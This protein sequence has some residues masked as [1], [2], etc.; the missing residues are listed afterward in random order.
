MLFFSSLTAYG[1]M[2]LF[3][4]TIWSTWG[5][6]MIVNNRVEAKELFRSEVKAKAHHL[7]DPDYLET[8]AL[9]QN[10]FKALAEGS[11]KLSIGEYEI[12]IKD[13]ES[14]EVKSLCKLA[15]AFFHARQ[16]LTVDKDFI[17]NI[18]RVQKKQALGNWSRLNKLK[19][20]V[21]VYENP[22]TKGSA[23]PDLQEQLLG[24]IKVSAP[25]IKKMEKTERWKKIAI[26]SG[27]LLLTLG[28]GA[29]GLAL[30]ILAGVAL[31]LFIAGILISVVGGN[32]S[33]S[34]MIAAAVGGK[35]KA[36]RKLMDEQELQ[37]DR[38][39]AF[40]LLNNPKKFEAFC[41]K[42]NLSD[43]QKI[44]VEDLLNARAREKE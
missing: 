40:Q 6:F 12:D 13:L 39:W 14:K 27:G 9:I 31:P 17:S 29:G 37:K 42:A 32:L 20:I 38:L 44:T 25:I 22:E 11:G 10:A 26:V 34:G 5:C 21:Y 30:T 3:L 16:N 43:P 41:E 36:Q 35:R 2:A 4:H 33:L 23:R 19:E 1:D 8:L 7:D 15:D 24:D 28:L 18:Q